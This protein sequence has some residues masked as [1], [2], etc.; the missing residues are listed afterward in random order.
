[1]VLLVVGCVAGVAFVYMN[2]MLLSSAAYK[3]SVQRAMSSPEV[4]N[5]LGTGIRVKYPVLGLAFPFGDSEFAEWSVILSGSG[6]S[7]HLYGVANQIHGTWEFSRLTFDPGKGQAR[8]D[9]T[10]VRQLRLP[11]V[12]AKN[13]YLVPIGFTDA[14]SLQWAPAYY[15]S[16]FGITLTVL[17]SVPMDPKL[18]DLSRGQLNASKCVDFLLEKYPEHARNPFS[19]LIGVTSSDMYIPDL[20]WAYA[21]NMRSDGRFAVISSARLHPPFPLAMWNPEWLTSRLQK[22]LTKNLGLL[23]FDLPMSSDYTSMLSGG[24]L[25]G[26]EIDLMG[27][28]LIGADGRWE[29]FVERGSPSVTIY[30]PPG[31]KLLWKIDETGSALPDTGSQVFCVSLGVGLFVQ[32]KADFVFEK[33]PALQFT[34]VYRNQDDRSR[35]FGIGG[36]HSFDIFLGGR[37]GV[38]VDLISESG[39]R[40]HFD[41]QQPRAGQWGDVYQPDSGTADGFANAKAIYAADSWTVKTTDGW[42]YIFPY[43]PQALPQYVTVLTSFVDPDGHKY[44]IER[45][46][47]GAIVGIASSSGNWL[48]FEDDAEHRIRKITSSQGRTMRYDYD[49]G[50]RLVR[51]EDSDANVDF[52]TYN[53][54]GEMLSV[55]HGGGKPILTNEYSSDGYI[56]SQIM[57]DGRKFEYAYFID[58]GTMRENQITDPNG[59]G[60]YI[61]YQPGGYLRSLPIPVP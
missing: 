61:Q 34:R 19:L 40:T 11:P 14:D 6:G 41:Y 37:M 59:M 7:G 54:K 55:A 30:D 23:Y 20:N 35:A 42:T 52:Y 24:V 21:Q 50:G 39:H 36:S 12:P 57:G 51:T 26:L 5:A 48:H 29:P 4:R 10:P 60:T 46:T 45:D 27:G 44:E 16:K 18:I 49:T 47:F 9:L 33:E 13:V 22:L 8:I 53:E 31:D 28:Q 38:A 43:K 3:D 15:K 32:R 17:P 58:G 25:S 2:V 1:M 56:K